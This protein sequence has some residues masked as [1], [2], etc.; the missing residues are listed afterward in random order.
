MDTAFRE[1][2]VGHLDSTL[3]VWCARSLEVRVGTIPV[4]F[5]AGGPR[6]GTNSIM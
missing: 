5:R 6:R 1:E 4:G 3:F 2:T